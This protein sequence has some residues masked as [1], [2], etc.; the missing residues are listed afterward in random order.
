M[1]EPISSGTIGTAMRSPTLEE[2]RERLLPEIKKLRQ[3]IDALIQRVA[4][5]PSHQERTGKELIVHDF[6]T[7][8]VQRE[9]AR[10]LIE[11]K[12]W[13]GKMLEYLGN[14]FPP[15]LADKSN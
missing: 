15:E 5:R 10:K 9:V 1:S 6:R 7:R 11:A 13:A 4:D 3:D 8:D 14:P 2:E 12:M